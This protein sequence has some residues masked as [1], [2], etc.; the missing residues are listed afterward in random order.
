[1]SGFW[2]SDEQQAIRY[3]VVRLCERFYAAYWRRTDETGVFP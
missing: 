1:M 3:A 2:F